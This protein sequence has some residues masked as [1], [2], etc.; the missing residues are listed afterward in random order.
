MN[1][2]IL[3]VD[4]IFLDRAKEAF[5]FPISNSIRTSFWIEDA[6][7]STFSELIVENENFYLDQYYHNVKIKIV[8][9]EFLSEKLH[10]GVKFKIGIFP[11]A[12]AEGQIDSID[13][14]GSP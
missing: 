13:I 14:V 4:I 6:E 2:I 3:I 1:E 7:N 8:E 5:N 11:N 12:I 10:K 9:R